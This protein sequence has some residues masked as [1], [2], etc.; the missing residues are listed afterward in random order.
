MNDYRYAIV[1]DDEGD[2]TTRVDT[3]GAMLV[4]MG[5]SDATMTVS[6]R[7]S[8]AGWSS[9]ILFDVTVTFWS[10]YAVESI[11]S[12]LNYF[13]SRDG[14]YVTVET[15]QYGCEVIRFIG[16]DPASGPDEWTGWRLGAAPERF[17]V[18]VNDGHRYAIGED[19][20]EGEPLGPVE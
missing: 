17:S 9:R 4:D 2:N 1:I 12:T 5:A 16:D 13:L 7:R 11:L 6:E 3:L 15:D 20:G 18:I 8:G 10:R 14:E 19:G